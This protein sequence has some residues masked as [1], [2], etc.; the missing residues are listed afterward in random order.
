MSDVVKVNTF[1][2][3][4]DRHFAAYNKVYLEY[5]P[6]EPPTRTTDRGEDLREHPR[7]DRVRRLFAPES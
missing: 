6:T 2:R 7:R 1:L 4:V 5:F 3:D